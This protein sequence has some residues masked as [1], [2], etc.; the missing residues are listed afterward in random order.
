[1]F[2]EF[3]VKILMIQIFNAVLYLNKKNVIHGDLKLENIM[4]DSCLN[5]DEITEKNGKKNNFIQSLLEDEKEINEYI[6]QTTL[7]RASTF[8][9]FG[10]KN[11]WQITN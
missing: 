9:D 1:M 10:N 4:V 2:P 8:H 3:F 5:G 11:L 6:R 7:K